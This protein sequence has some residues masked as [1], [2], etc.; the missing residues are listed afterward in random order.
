M[1]LKNNLK[2]VT[3][4]LKIGITLIMLLFAICFLQFIVYQVGFLLTYEGSFR[5]STEPEDQMTYQL[6]DCIVAGNKHYSGYGVETGASGQTGPEVNYIENNV[7][8]TGQVVFEKDKNKN[9]YLHV[10]PSTF[11][12][13]LG[14]GLFAKSAN[15]NVKDKNMD[16]K[17]Y[18]TNHGDM[19]NPGKYVDMYEG[20]PDDVNQLCKIVQGSLIHVFHA[21]RYDV[22]PTE[23]QKKDVQLRNVEDMLEQIHQ[24]DERP[25]RFAR[26]PDKRLVGNCRHFAVLL[27]SMLRHKNIP[28][29]ARCGFATY[30]PSDGMREDHWICE[31]WNEK[32]ARWVQVDAQLDPVQLEQM[33]ID[34]NPLDLP[35]GAF[36]PAGTAWQMCKASQEDPNRFGFSDMKGMWFISGNVVRD[37]MALNKVELL[38][39]DN[40]DLMVGPKESPKE[41]STS[42]K[43]AMI[44]RLAELSNQPDD[45]FK[46]L[47]SLYKKDI[48][49]SVDK[50]NLKID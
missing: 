10:I 44:N 23:E 21:H 26:E 32:Q 30:F 9:G 3:S 29:R 20:L 5:E 41:K 47:R 38:P 31:Y 46:Q 33:H 43:E 42:E 18:Y 39:W 19:S 11:G 40:M 27:C 45:N 50:G 1:K 48:R 35:K 13:E 4:P 25:I 14:A 24:S 37:F 2:Y 8:K 7:L 36:L 15:E 17:R 6:R 16:I 22:T 49:F 12:S 34:I 28:A